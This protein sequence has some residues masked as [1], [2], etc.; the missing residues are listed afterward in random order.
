MKITILCLIAVSIF[1]AACKHIDLYGNWEVTSVS[2]TE[3][4]E[5]PVS[6]NNADVIGR[7]YWLG[8]KGQYFAFRK[9]KTVVTNIA[10]KYNLR[11]Y[12]YYVNSETEKNAEG[13]QRNGDFVYFYNYE[14]APNDTFSLEI[15]QFSPDSMTWILDGTYTLKL[16]NIY[17]DP[18]AGV[19]YSRAFVTRVF[20]SFT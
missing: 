1:F 20:S 10:G 4:N 8:S 13:N 3:L 7:A 9:D 11:K 5:G 19:P 17:K 6:E 2:Q 15:S 16:K 18:D 12:S 14:Q